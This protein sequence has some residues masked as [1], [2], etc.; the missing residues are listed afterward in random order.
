MRPE[1]VLD[2]RRALS[3]SRVYSRFQRTFRR[4][5]SM[6]RLVGLLDLRPGQR[7]LD[8]GCGPADI[9]AYLPHDIEYHG[10]DANGSYIATASRRYGNRGRFAQRTVSLDAADEVG[11]FDV[12]MALGV[13]HHLTDADAGI[14]FASAR[15]LLRPNGR[16]FTVDGAYV[17]GQN[18]IARL[19]LA[20]DRGKYVR[21]PEEYLAI[22]RP[23]FPQ[24]KASVL[25]DLLAIPYTHCIVQASSLPAGQGA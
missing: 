23:Y 6:A 12:V 19:L 25:H 13:L 2:P 7:V 20:L 14:V 8:I 24:A 1:K 18:P 5:S 16:I 11:A 4:D 21:R 10:Y 9:L 3:N 22:A 15:K 17:Q